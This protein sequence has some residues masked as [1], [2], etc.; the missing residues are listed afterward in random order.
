MTPV[1]ERSDDELYKLWNDNRTTTEGKKVAG[2]LWNRYFD[3]IMG[4]F[5][6]RLSND[7]QDVVTETLH[8][9]IMG[10][11]YRGEGSFRG[12]VYGVARNKLFKEYKRRSKV[13]DFD[14][15]VSSLNDVGP[16]V[17]YVMD[18]RKARALVVEALRRIPIENQMAIDAYYIEGDSGPKVAEMLDITVPALRNRLRRGLEKVRVVLEQLE[19]SGEEFDKSRDVLEAW[20]ASLPGADD[21]VESNTPK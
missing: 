11:N 21:D 10:T 3:Q 15:S 12:F 1:D 19:G 2:Q 7:I 18:K 20:S 16:S 14:P 5:R 6:K 4:Y 9:A 8:V 17:T 13:Q